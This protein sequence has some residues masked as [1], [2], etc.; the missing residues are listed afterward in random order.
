MNIT[1]NCYGNVREAVE[2]QSI[3]LTLEQGSTVS[4]VFELLAVE[5]AGFSKLVDENTP[6]VVMRDGIHLDR[7]TKLADGDALSLST[8]PMP[9]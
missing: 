9:E 1:V 2:T 5:H 3:D 8:S 4:D 6:L 7:D